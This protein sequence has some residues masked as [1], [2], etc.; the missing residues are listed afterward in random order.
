M[1][2]E[3]QQQERRGNTISSLNAAI[4]VLNLAGGISDIIPAKVV[5]GTV[6]VLL[7]AIRVCFPLAYDDRLRAETSLGFD[8]QPGRFRRTWAGMRQRL[9]RPLRSVERE[10][11]ERP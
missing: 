7:V 4:E 1:G 5:F 3:T 11:V 6:S 8:D 10:D 2:T 9:Y